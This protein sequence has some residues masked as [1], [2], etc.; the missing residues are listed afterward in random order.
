MPLLEEPAV[1]LVKWADSYRI[2]CSPRSWE[3]WLRG[4]LLNTRRDVVFPVSHN[5]KMSH[6]DQGKM[7][8]GALL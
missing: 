1:R 4:K 7:A 5:P 3:R 6:V 8:C 2:N